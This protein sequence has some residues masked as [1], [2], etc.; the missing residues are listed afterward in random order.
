[1][2]L[3]AFLKPEHR[4]RW[5]A[6]FQLFHLTLLESDRAARGRSL[7]EKKKKKRRRKG[8]EKK[9]GNFKE[10]RKR[11]KEKRKTKG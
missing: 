1:M 3:D 5:A 8:R 11:E 10:R 6:W 9:E 4:L 7:F 2:V